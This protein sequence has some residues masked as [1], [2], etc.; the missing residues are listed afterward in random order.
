MVIFIN[1]PPRGGE[2]IIGMHFVR[3]SVCPF[4]TFCV[5]AVT[6]ICIDGLASNLVQMLS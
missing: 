1:P 5:R 2:G 6:Y 3:P 4:V